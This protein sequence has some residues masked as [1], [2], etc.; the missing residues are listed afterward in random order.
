MLGSSFVIFLDGGLVDLNVLG[1]NDRDDLG[2]ALAQNT[3]LGEC[4]R[5]Q[6]ALFA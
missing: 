4:G 3:Q 6:N 5:A 1:L 2:T